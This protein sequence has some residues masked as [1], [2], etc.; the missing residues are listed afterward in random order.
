[1]AS[2]P[3]G[4]QTE[5]AA[6]PTLVHGLR[7]GLKASFVD[8]VRRMPDGRGSVGDGALPVGQG[9]L[10][11][12]FDGPL[13]ESRGWS[14]RGDVRFSGHMGMLFVRIARPQ[15]TL[16]GD[17]FTL[18]VED[19][20]GVEDAPRLL[21]VTG[22]IR[23]VESPSGTDVWLSEDVRLTAAG[24]EVFNDAYAEGEPFEPIIV[25]VPSA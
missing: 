19:P 9:D 12:E 17:T 15:V 11:F 13:D 21:L 4:Q 22:T 1:M 2:S 16:S 23:R 25:Q 10:F 7:W 20:A 5:P 18:S 8:Y 6:A 14:F 3:I 24:A